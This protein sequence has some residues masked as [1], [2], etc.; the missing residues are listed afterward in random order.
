MQYP[1]VEYMGIK[2]AIFIVCFASFAAFPASGRKVLAQAVYGQDTTHSPIG[3]KQVVIDKIFIVGNRKTKENIILREMKLREGDAM[4]EQELHAELERD[5][6]KILNTSLFLSV[7]T[8]VLELGGNKVDI[9]IRVTERWYFFP[10]PVFQLADRNFNDWWVNQEHD[11]NRVN[12]GLK[13]YMYNMR[14]RNE[15]LKLVAQAGF[16]KGFQAQY[17]FPYIDAGQKLGLTLTAEHLENDNFNYI[18]IGGKQQDLGFLN[19]SKWLLRES[20]FGMKFKYRKSFYNSHDFYLDY[21]DDRVKDTVLTYNPHYLLDG[22]LRQKYFQLKYTFTRD[23]RDVTA[24]PLNGFLLKFEAEKSGLG[25]LDD[26]NFFSAGVNYALFLDVGKGFYLSTEAGAR[27]TWPKRQ[28]Y[29]NL[30]ALGFQPYDIRG[31]ELYVIEGQH[32]F[33]NRNTFKKRVFQM[34]MTNNMIP[35]RQFRHFPLALYAKTFVDYGYAINAWSVEDDN[36]LVNNHLFGAGAGLDIVTYYDLS[37]QLDYSINKLG[38][39]G[40]VLGVRRLF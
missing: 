28:P 2:F 21:F 38:E 10:V 34:N 7:N 22:Q 32:I 19:S 36:R 5:R 11:F 40:F 14:G 9:I 26:L 24:Y 27:T 30:N 17:S 20:H 31:Y 16:T 1:E 18:T 25:I 15:T 35:L 4:D 13:I 37:V 33:H 23:L 39:T 29:H 12:Y 6:N 3:E 8:N